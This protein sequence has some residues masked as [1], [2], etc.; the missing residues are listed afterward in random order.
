MG[1]KRTEQFEQ[2]ECLV[3]TIEGEYPEG[4]NNVQPWK[5]LGVA[6]TASHHHEKTHVNLSAC[7]CPDCACGCSHLH[8]WG[9]VYNPASSACMA[10]VMAGVPVLC[11]CVC[12]FTCGRVFAR[13]WPLAAPLIGSRWG[14][15]P[16][17][18]VCWRRQELDKRKGGLL[19]FRWCMDSHTPN[20]DPPLTDSFPFNWGGRQI[21]SDNIC[22]R[23]FMA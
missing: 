22:S 7:P 1:L 6:M 15:S 12:V 16:S 21:E 2:L 17:A 13:A 11:V 4:V 14:L 5:T 19:L 3:L 10:V 18:C 9:H 8:V 23:E 20:K